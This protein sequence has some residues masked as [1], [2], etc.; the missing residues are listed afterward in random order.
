MGTNV[1]VNRKPLSLCPIVA[2]FKTISLKYD[3]K[4]ILNEFIHYLFCLFVL[5]FYGPV[6]NEVMWY[7]SWAGLDLL[8]GQPF[9]SKD[10]LLGSNLRLTDE[11]TIFQSWSAVSQTTGHEKWKIDEI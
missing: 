11:T 7:C 10:I 4:H 6:N 5:G 3:F 1:D 9:L 8:S 2:S